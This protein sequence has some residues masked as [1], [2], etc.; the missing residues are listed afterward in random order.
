MT[1]A[2]A[3][4]AGTDTGCLDRPRQSLESKNAAKDS[5]VKGQRSLC[6]QWGRAGPQVLVTSSPSAS[7]FLGFIRQTAAHDPILF[8]LS[9]L[10]SL[11]LWPCHG[12]PGP[13]VLM[14]SWQPQRVAIEMV[15][16]E[17]GCCGQMELLLRQGVKQTSQTASLGPAALVACCG[18]AMW[19]Y[20]P[21]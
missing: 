3:E 20:R 10:L 21:S 9:P 4:R 12:C 16:R 8:L 1:R 13:A 18:E 7:L 6:L 19:Q 14:W 2:W 5:G 17:E 15:A 11:W